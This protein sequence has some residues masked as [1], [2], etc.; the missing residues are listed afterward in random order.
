MKKI[1]GR[2][3]GQVKTAMFGKLTIRENGTIATAEVARIDRRT[4]LQMARRITWSN[5]IS[6]YRVMKDGLRDGWENI[7][8]GQSLYNQFIAVNAK[9][10]PYALRQDDFK[11]GAC[12]VAPYLVT[13]GSLDPIRVDT[14]RGV[15]LATTGIRVGD[16]TVDESTTIGEFAEAIVTN[17]ADWKYGDKLTYF[18]LVQYAQGG[19]PK[20]TM[21]YAAITLVEG[22]DII[23]SDE[24]SL[25]GIRNVNGVLGHDKAAPLGGFCWVHSRHDEGNALLLSTQ[26]IVTNNADMIARYTTVDARRAAAE[27][28][29]ANFKGLKVLEPADPDIKRMYGYFGIEFKEAKGETKVTPTDISL[30]G[31][32]Y[33]DKFVFDGDKAIMLDTVLADKLVLSGSNLSALDSSATKVV[34]DGVEITGATLKDN[35]LTVT[36]P[37]SLN[38]KPLQHLVLTDGTISTVLDLTV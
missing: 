25:N 19:I 4:P 23:L 7:P 27:S 11:A 17:N 2:Y 9:A 30:S 22:S 35:A 34:I 33:R 24:V 29:G 36:L 38:G 8:Q 18:S 13:R 32:T 28:Y 3:I 37:S 20:V 31:L 26:R 10:E 15:A 6:T 12:V 16:L 5:I 14:T 21:S 1:N